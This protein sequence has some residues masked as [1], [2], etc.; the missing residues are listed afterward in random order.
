MVWNDLLFPMLLLNGK[1]NFTLPLAVL[2]FRGEY[3]TDYPVL[4]TGVLVT[5]LPLVLVF[6]FLQ[7]Y[8]IAGLADGALKG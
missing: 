1:S 2:Q 8:F 7:R 6:L 3:V 5:A 4:L